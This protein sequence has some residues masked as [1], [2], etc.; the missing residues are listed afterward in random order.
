MEQ[1]PSLEPALIDKRKEL[2]DSAVH[3]QKLT[4]S[5]MELQENKESVEKAL[6][7]IKSNLEALNQDVKELMSEHKK[8]AGQRERKQ[9]HC[10]WFN[11]QRQSKHYSG[12]DLIIINQ[13]IE[14]MELKIEQLTEQM[15]KLEKM[16]ATQEDIAKQLNNDLV[17]KQRE[18]DSLQQRLKILANELASANAELEDHRMRHRED[19]ERMKKEAEIVSI[20]LSSCVQ[21]LSNC[22]IKKQSIMIAKQEVKIEMMDQ[23]LKH[24]RELELLALAS[25]GESPRAMSELSLS[26]DDSSDVLIKWQ[27]T[28]NCISYDNYMAQCNG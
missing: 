12:Q 10:C 3:C 23:E 1:A 21:F 5:Q 13:V 28:R 18:K 19:I 6:E 24:R 16:I 9:A 8:L 15:N 14:D 20:I 4:Q 17:Q 2:I 11:N 7:D 25:A 22:N 27:I 26:F